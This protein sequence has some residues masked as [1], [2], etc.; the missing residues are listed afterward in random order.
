MARP[1]D[2]WGTPS[3]SSRVIRTFASFGLQARGTWPGST[4]RSVSLPRSSASWLRS[5]GPEQTQRRSRDR[6]ST[7][8]HRM[9]LRWSMEPRH[10]VTFRNTGPAECSVRRSSYTVIGS[11]NRPR[12]RPRTLKPRLNR[13]TARRFVLPLL[14]VSGQALDASTTP[15]VLDGRLH[16]LRRDSLASPALVTHQ[17]ASS[18]VGSDPG[19]ALAGKAQLGNTKETVLPPGPRIAQGPKLC[20]RQCSAAA[21][22]SRAAASDFPDACWCAASSSRER[23]VKTSRAVSSTISSTIWSPASPCTL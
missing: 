4:S 18:S 19:D 1:S 10:R 14:D 2:R 5:R 12:P 23:G 16:R 17:P 20:C 6:Q 15:D 22:V 13:E 9:G 21:R 3:P 7:A 8:R 11:P